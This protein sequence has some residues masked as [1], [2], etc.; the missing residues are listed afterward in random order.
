M[1]EFTAAFA[2]ALKPAGLALS[3]CTAQWTSY[4]SDFARVLGAGGASA[5]YDMGMYHGLSASEWEGKLANASSA[6]GLG[7]VSDGRL[8]VGFALAPKYAW[9]NTTASVTERFEIMRRHGVAHA[10]VF[11]W[12]GG[13]RGVATFGLPPEVA[14]EYTTQL[15]RFVSGDAA[16]VARMADEQS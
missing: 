6:A 2:R 9:E 4:G 10:A 5:V 13:R 12:A 16:Q 1:D 3:V 7:S 15:Q 14:A 11:A 8:A